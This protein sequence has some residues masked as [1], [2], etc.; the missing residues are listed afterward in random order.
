M[1]LEDIAQVATAEQEC[2]PTGWGPTPFQ[3]ELQNKATAYLVA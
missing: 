3:R 2:F 1:R